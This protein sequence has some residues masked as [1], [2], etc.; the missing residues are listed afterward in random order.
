MDKNGAKVF[1]K[2]VG[3]SALAV[4]ERALLRPP[5]SGWV[6]TACV[7]GLVKGHGFSSAVKG[8]NEWGFSPCA[9]G[10]R[11]ARALPG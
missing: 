1:L 7:R 11:E 4:R 8:S 6:N 5:V 3:Y 2:A 9:A 10:I